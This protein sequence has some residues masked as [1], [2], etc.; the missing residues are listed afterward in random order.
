MAADEFYKRFGRRL[1]K[2][3]KEAGLSQLELAGHIGLSRTSITNI[4][5][6]RQHVQIHTLY[7]LAHALG[8]DSADLLPAMP[9]VTV[10][11]DELARHSEKL[12]PNEMRQLNDL[13]VKER[14]WLNQIAQPFSKKITDGQ[15]ELNGKNR[16]GS[17]QVTEG[18]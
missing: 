10:L 9:E 14:Q 12:R 4:E 1:S 2:F 18:Q 16:K 11:N 15:A 6:G 8:V 5:R 13:G 3:R 7:S 17:K